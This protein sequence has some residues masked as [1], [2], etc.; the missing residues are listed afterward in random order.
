MREA[1]ASVL[2][3]VQG[4]VVTG[5]GALLGLLTLSPI[6]LVLVLP[7]LVAG[8]AMFALALP[9]MARRQRISILA[10]ERDR[11]VGGRRR[12]RDARRRRRAARRTQVAATVGAH[13]D[14]QARATHELARF[15]ALRTRRGRRR[16]PAAARPDPRRGAV[17]ARPRRKHGRDPR[18]ADVRRPGRASCPADARSRARQYGAV[19]VRHARADRRGD[20][21]AAARRPPPLE[22]AEPRGCDVVLRDVTFG[23][24]RA[25]EPV[26][27]APR[28]CDHRRRA[29]R[30]RRPQ[31]RRQVDARRARRGPDRAAAR[32]R[33]ARRDRDRRARSGDGG[34]PSR[35][36]PAAGVRLRGNAAREPRLPAPRRRRRDARRRRRPA[37]SAGA[38]ASASAASTASSIRTRCRPAS[39]SS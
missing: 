9:G 16:R 11:R 31:R 20:R 3:V 4:F 27:D 23:Y 34:A 7:P 28:P 10:D 21:G 33:V 30:G 38:R 26:I 24:G 19:A 8:L 36:D 2:L 22:S 39:A 15:T 17:A 14:A 6:V 37:R 35:A 1:Y 29:P 25:V 12:R 18:R 13:I 5:V 32:R